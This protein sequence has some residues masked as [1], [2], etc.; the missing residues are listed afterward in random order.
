MFDASTALMAAVA[1]VLS[2]FVV[3]ILRRIYDRSLHGNISED[4]KQSMDS[5]QQRLTLMFGTHWPV[6]TLL[7]VLVFYIATESAYG[8]IQNQADSSKTT[9][10]L[11]AMLAILAL[12]G[13]LIAAYVSYEESGLYSSLQTNFQRNTADAQATKIQRRGF[14]MWIVTT[15][16]IVGV[17]A[18]IYAKKHHIQASF[19][20]L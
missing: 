19:D 17:A 12:V 10:A 9:E 6:V 16:L 4:S 5:I 13:S 11:A 2:T 20:P 7:V 3:L 18:G 15:L 1:I 14:F 8:Q